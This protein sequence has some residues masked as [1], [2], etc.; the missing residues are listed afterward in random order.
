MKY[1]AVA[2]GASTGGIRALK[3]ILSTLPKR[4]SASILIVQHLSPYSDNFLIQYLKDLCKIQVKEAN[5]KELVQ[6]GCAYIAP[7]NYHLMIEKDRHLSLSVEKK[8]NFSRPSIDVLFES[9]ADAYGDRLIGII[10]TG[11]SCDGSKGLEEV[12][13]RGGL[14]IVEEPKSAEAYIMPSAAIAR[15]KVDYVL[16]LDRI[17]PLLNDLVG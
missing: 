4:F 7:P 13:A 5:E 16:P 14:T 9:A 6:K 15:T 2:I 11:A 12:K 3:M 10:L 8:V 1:E 17:G